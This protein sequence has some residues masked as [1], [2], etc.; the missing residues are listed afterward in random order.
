MTYPWGDGARLVVSVSGGKD[1]T[2]MCLHLRDKGQP[3]EAVFMDTGWETQETYDYLRDVLPG[4]VGDITW[5]RAEVPLE[6]EAEALA[7]HY[8]ER[9]GFYSAFVRKCL[10]YAGFPGRMAR[11][12]TSELKVEPV[13]KHLQSMEDEPVN[14]V[15]IR[16]EESRSRSAMPE[17]EYSDRLDCWVWRPLIDWT[18]DDVIDIHRRHGIRPNPLYLRSSSRVGCWPCIFA[19]K[20]ELRAIDQDRVDI[21]RDLERDLAPM[22][23]ERRAAKGKPPRPPPRMFTTR[24]GG[25]PEDPWPIDDVMTWAMTAHGG[26]Q[27]ELFASPARDAG[28]VRWGMCDTGQKEDPPTQR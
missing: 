23:A 15:G 14:V 9:L 12:C 6:G 28:C 19:R 18:L 20:A 10:K 8:E 3:F 11:W 26:R 1:S 21:I 2:A 5:L 27:F 25:G 17:T 24:R 7:L 22:M 13:L 4:V 16:A